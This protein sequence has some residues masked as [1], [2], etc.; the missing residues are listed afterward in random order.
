MQLSQRSF[1][2]LFVADDS[3]LP[4]SGEEYNGNLTSNQYKSAI[5]MT[6]LTMSSALLF[7]CGT[8]YTSGYKSACE[9]FAA[10]FVE[11]S[12]SID[13]LFVFIMLFDY[14]KVP[15]QYQPRVLT[16]GIVGAVLMR[17]VM[18]IFG[19]AAVRMFR[20]VTVIFALILLASAYKLLG[21]D[22]KEDL[23]ENAI[24][25]F[26]K[27][28]IRST[29]EYDGDRFF[30][31]ERNNRVATPLFMCLVCIELS[32]LIFAVDSIPAVLGISN[33]PFIVYTSNIFA[34]MSLR[35]LYTVIAKAVTD[36][37]YLRISVAIVL[38]FISIKM[39]AEYFHISVPIGISLTVI[40]SILS[41]GI[42]V[43]LYSKDRNYSNI[44][45]ALLNEKEDRFLV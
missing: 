25:K 26:S 14:F 34:I 21:E 15:L 23:Q 7:G 17:G 16:W 30:T 12:L 36:L 42:G 24:M 40:F 4:I 35:S 9:F 22:S 18:I 41:C 38:A 13:N 43:S 27:M 28:F 19:V 37:S 45:N 29:T 32:D 1:T 20:S 11:Q 6:A 44:A 39:I 2:K 33:D 10:Y 3:I 31:M 8:Y 5:R